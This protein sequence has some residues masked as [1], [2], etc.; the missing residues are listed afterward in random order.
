MKLWTE[1]IGR[2]MVETIPPDGGT[3]NTPPS[4][5]D[6]LLI[7]G[8]IMSAT[9]AHM[10]LDRDP[11]LHITIVE[12]L[13]QLAAESSSAWHNAGTGHAGL[14]ELNYTPELPSGEIDTQKAETM[15]R[16]FADNLAAWKRWSA[17]GILGR[18]DS[19]LTP[20]PHMTFV[21]GE[22]DS[23]FL[24]KRH[25]ALRELPG[26]EELEFS[27][28][29]DR[30]AEWAPLL[31]EGRADGPVAA[32][33]HHG[34]FDV[35]FGALTRQLFDSATRRG[36]T[37]L[38]GTEVTR[39]TSDA[40]HSWRATL[41]SSQDGAATG[42]IRARRVFVGAGG[43]T[44]QLL[45]SAGL[46][47][48]RGY[49]LLPVSGKFLYSTAESVVAKHRAKVYGKAP[50]GAPPMSMP[51]LDA[52]VIDGA[53]AVLFG[54][55]AGTSPRFLLRG[56][57][58]DAARSLQSHNLV[59][60]ASMAT[61]NLPLVSLLAKEVFA[62]S[63]AKQEHLREFA[64]MADIDGWTMRAAGQ[65]AQIVKPGSAHRGELQFGTEVV[66]SSD[67]SL[68]GVLGASPGASTA[69]SIVEEILSAG[70]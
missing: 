70:F 46:P 9:A 5:T 69:V 44:L 65:R 50:V 14:C 2:A 26:F 8:G 49:G 22:A 28:D 24:R 48:V 37:I 35:D 51:H 68:V 3:V 4:S 58:W 1:R 38:T 6:V 32:T 10:L 40:A 63:A 21:A 52:R 60:L 25:A 17:D 66:R 18:L 15:N 42:T 12:R 39:L 7:G 43:W 11:Q 19:F 45:Q 16:Q 33:W 61:H 47:Q 54:P 23:A 53:P 20:V 55:F 34:G 30:I 67:G 13:D 31:T 41:R 29:R 64:P 56:H 57:W 62:S 36:A 59:P 27:T